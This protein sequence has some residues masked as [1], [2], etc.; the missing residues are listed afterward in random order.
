M[1][2]FR[3]LAERLEGLKRLLKPAQ[4]WLIV[5]NADPDAM[6][7]AMA[8]RL[9]LERRA[10]RA[11]IAHINPIARPDNLAMINVL[12]IPMLRLTPELLK[13]YDKF[14]MVDSQP[15]HNP[16]FAGIDFDIVLDHHPPVPEHPVVASYMEIRPEYGA[17]STLLT[18]YLYNLGI[19]PGRR[20]ATAL[21][22][23]IKTDTQSFE[24]DF[25][26]V[27]VKAF[28]YLSKLSNKL[29]LRKIVH[30]EFLKEWLDSFALAYANSRYLGRE[31]FFAWLGDVDNPDILVVLAD[32]FLR[33]HGIAW[34]AIAGCSNGKVV[35]IFRCDGLGGRDM[36]KRAAG[37]FGAFGSAGGHKMAARAEIPLERLG[38]VDPECFVLGRITRSKAAAVPAGGGA[39]S[40]SCS[41]KTT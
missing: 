17:V 4:R 31:G 12:H 27:D 3:L 1:A 7:S 26:G 35:V 13:N 8:L 41:R 11:D 14:A 15:H 38:G 6:A 32:F 28:S 39:L 21:L 37:W 10:A 19:V 16:E 25:C 34:D 20:L 5:I 2:F 30:A 33:V 36:G 24:R 40:G 22:Y 9:I 29:L 18:E 23:G